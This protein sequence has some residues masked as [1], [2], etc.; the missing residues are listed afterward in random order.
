VGNPRC[1]LQ[2]GQEVEFKFYAPKT[3]KNTP[4]WAA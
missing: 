1:E 2:N 4:F 3:T